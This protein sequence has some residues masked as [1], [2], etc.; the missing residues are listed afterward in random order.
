MLQWLGRIVFLSTSI[1]S[2]LEYAE[3][4]STPNTI[5][6][7][8][9]SPTIDNCLIGGTSDTAISIM[10][11]PNAVPNITKNIISNNKDGISL[12]STNTNTITQISKN[13]IINNSGSGITVNHGRPLIC[14]NRIA[15]NSNGI[16]YF[17][18]INGNDTCTI[19]DNIISN[20]TCGININPSGFGRVFNITK[21]LIINNDNA[22]L[23]QH[24]M[25]W[26]AGSGYVTN[27]T[28][29]KNNNGIISNVPVDLVINQNNIYQN[30]NYFVKLASTSDTNAT[31]NWWGTTDTTVISQSIY[32]FYDDFN[33]GK[34]IFNPFLTVLSTTAPTVPIFTIA[35]SAGSGGSISPNESVSV[36]IFT[37]PLYFGL[38]AF[39][40]LVYKD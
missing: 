10:A 16:Y 22:I 40:G 19:L 7:I 8:Y 11:G 3:I 15:N 29:A 33:L 30:S 13:E 37:K 28:I 17:G 20:N 4:T 2:K 1:D 31:N 5:I 24:F 6:G 12:D 9:S 34:I 18:G 36:S 25:G 39:N 14:E 23:L 35:A 32:D 26:S 27:N 21:N 38:I